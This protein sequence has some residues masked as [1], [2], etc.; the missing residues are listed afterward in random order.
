M[1]KGENAGVAGYRNFG[2]IVQQ[3]DIWFGSSVV[4]CRGGIPEALGSNPGGAIFFFLYYRLH[5]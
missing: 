1:R 4:E 3:I 2:D 5:W